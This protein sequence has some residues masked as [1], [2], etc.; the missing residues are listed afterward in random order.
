MDS[1]L[2]ASLPVLY[3]YCSDFINSVLKQKKITY[4]D[5]NYNLLNVESIGII[6]SDN[7]RWNSKEEYYNFLG[8]GEEKIIFPIKKKNNR[9]VVIYTHYDSDNIIKNYVLESIKILI[10]LG[11]DI[12]FF[13]SSEMI[14]NVNSIPFN[15]NY[16]KNQGIGTDWRMLLQGLNM[17]NNSKYEWVM[18]INDSLILGVNGISNFE[19]VIKEQRSSGNH[20]WGQ[21][22][23]RHVD[24]H[25]I[26]S[27][28]EFK[29]ELVSEIINFISEALPICKTYFDYIIKLEIGF[30]K[31]LLNKGYTL[32]AVYNDKNFIFKEAGFYYPANIKKWINNPNTFAIKW[33]YTISYLNKDVVSPELNYLT[34]FLYYGP[35]GTIS[36]GEI[37]GDYPKSID[38]EF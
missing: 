20:F 18:F 19:N 12:L 33:K 17:I 30:T 29:I 24:L 10:Y 38:F 25:L 21:H 37:Q 28:V 9:G 2:Y 36:K 16:L 15:I 11:Y 4:D 5:L 31:N 1:S 8:Y 27:P 32:S 23:T 35:Y 14:N 26:G 3:N 22:L 13:T 34:R 6:Q 7:L